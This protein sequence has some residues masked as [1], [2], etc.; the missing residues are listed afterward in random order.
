MAMVIVLENVVFVFVFVFVSEIL[1]LSPLRL[2]NKFEFVALFVADNP[3]KVQLNFDIK[4]HGP[5]PMVYQ[6]FLVIDS[7]VECGRA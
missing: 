6:Y 1:S 2:Q 3:C 5:K 7:I 4:I